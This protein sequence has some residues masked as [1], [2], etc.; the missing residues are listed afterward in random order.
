[1]KEKKSSA[2]N[3]VL[4][5]SGTRTKCNVYQRKNNSRNINGVRQQRKMR[6]KDGKRQKNS[7]RRCVCEHKKRE[8]EIKIES[9]NRMCV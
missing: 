5:S 6:E 1:M 8:S 3:T 2:M 9:A 7:M 4:N